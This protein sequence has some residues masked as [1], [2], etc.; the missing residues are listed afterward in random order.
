M[1]GESGQPPTFKDLA[2]A[3]GV[4]HHM[5][6]IDVAAGSGD[7]ESY[8][9]GIY[10][11][12][13][14]G[15]SDVDHMIDLVGYS[16][17]TSLDANGNCAF[18]NAGRPIN[19]DGYLLVE[20]NWGEEWGVAAS[21]GHMGYMKTRMYGADGSHCN[22]VATDALEFTIDPV[23]VAKRARFLCSVISFLPWC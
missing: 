5:L 8:S 2:F 1:L 17:E 9:S 22:A 12:C 20:N 16:C 13:V 7:W 6:S 14:G 4:D 21:N 10:D 3:V 23:P 19:Q 15:A 11:G 18:D